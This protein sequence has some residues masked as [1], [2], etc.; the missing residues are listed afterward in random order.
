M[1]IAD[2]SYDRDKYHILDNLRYQF[3]KAIEMLQSGH[4][5]SCIFFHHGLYTYV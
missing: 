3:W 2:N 4:N 1:Q 5:D